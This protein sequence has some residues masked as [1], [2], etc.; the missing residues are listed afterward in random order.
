VH[1][2]DYKQLKHVRDQFDRYMYLGTDSPGEIP[3]ER[4]AR[5]SL[6][7][8]DSGPQQ[9]PQSLVLQAIVKGG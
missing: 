5:G 6:L 7:A 4:L 8:S 9:G 2:L 3:R 1:S